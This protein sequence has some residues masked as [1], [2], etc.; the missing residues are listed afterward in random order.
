[1][2]K[3]TG[4][5]TKSHKKP[6][7]GAKFSER[8]ELITPKIA[9]KYLALLPPNQRH[10]RKKDVE[11]YAA[12]MKAGNWKFAGDPI[13]FN[14]HDELMDGQHR[15]RAVVLSGCTIEFVVLR[16]VPDDAFMVLDTGVARTPGDLLKIAGYQY[17]SNVAAII[18]HL[19]SL[20]EVESGKYQPSSFGKR[21]STPEI[22]L[23]YAE[24]HG[25][26]LVEAA[27]TTM[28]KDAKQV[29]SPPALFG[30]LYFAF[31]EYNKKGADQFF[32][33]LVHG[34]A[35]DG[36]GF[37]HG[38]Q[39]PVYQ[40]R[41][42]MLDLKTSKHKRR[43]PFYKAAVAIKAWNAFQE[44]DK[45]GTLRFSEN[46]GWPEINRRRTRLREDAAEKRDKKRSAEERQR[47]KQAASARTRRARTKA[48]K[49][50]RSAAS[51]KGAA[52]KRT[53]AA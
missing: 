36:T 45:I 46:E 5:K 22:L 33:L 4:T 34:M 51:K 48:K 53:R 24:R 41:R 3:K 52:T 27:K 15:L 35:E 20:Y 6:K 40:L 32:Q 17:T 42:F 14:T 2:A 49:T 29:C 43:P 26:A 44:R 21:K 18:R 37:E 30:A 11:R 28:S 38:R 23:E 7:K 13:R 39:D 25:D 47:E 50:A 10:L 19:T 1:M 16:N 9:E 12:A 8:R 31:A